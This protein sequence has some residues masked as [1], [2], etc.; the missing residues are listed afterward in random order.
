MNARQNGV[1]LPKSAVIG[2]AVVLALALLA[3]IWWKTG[4]HVRV[5][6]YSAATTT[7]ESSP[8]FQQE[9]QAQQ[10]AHGKPI[11]ES[12]AAKESAAEF[13]REQQQQPNDRR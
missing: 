1:E 6:P 3:G 12:I 10:A 11:D 4:T 13:Q 2:V 9:M 7:R 8:Q 5:D